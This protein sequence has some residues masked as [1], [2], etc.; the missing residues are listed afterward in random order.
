MIEGIPGGTVRADG[1]D[2]APSILG[3]ELKSLPVTFAMTLGFTFIVAL[4]VDSFD[5]GSLP[6]L[7]LLLLAFALVKVISKRPEFDGLPA[8]PPK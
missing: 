1:C 2:G 5:L 6:A 3:A 7:V 8:P 4:I